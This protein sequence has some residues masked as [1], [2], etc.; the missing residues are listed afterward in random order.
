MKISCN[1]IRD[2]LPM[3]TEDMVSNDT[4]LLV[5]KHLSECED[6]RNTCHE[7]QKKVELPK[8]TDI[9][10]LKALSMKLTRGKIIAAAVAIVV[11]AG[12]LGGMWFV[13]T[14]DCIVRVSFTGWNNMFHVPYEYYAIHGTEVVRIP[15]LFMQ[16]AC[17]NAVSNSHYDE[18]DAASRWLTELLYTEDPAVYDTF[19]GA[20]SP[21][22]SSEYG[23]N[24]RVYYNSWNGNG[25]APGEDAIELMR[26][27]AHTFHNGDPDVFSMISSLEGYRTLTWFVVNQCGD[28]TLL[29]HEGESLYL[30][31][32]DG[33][34]QLLM[35]CPDYG[36][37]DYFY[38][39]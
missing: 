4:K 18:T 23:E 1:V 29:E 35:E 27:A 12:L 5:E 31:M 20:A 3:Y 33:T 11:I 30:S 6:C 39:P 22:T 36:D 2:L 37:F 26:R 32:G 9:S 21:W 10:S 8:F 16:L 19:T 14:S 34:F 17:P 24:Y 28:M 15:G 38:F 25:I 7:M 13:G